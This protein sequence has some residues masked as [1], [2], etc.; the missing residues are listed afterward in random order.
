MTW[1][2]VTTR[3]GCMILKINSLGSK[4]LPQQ[5][6]VSQTLHIP[7]KSLSSGL[8]L[9]WLLGDNLWTLGIFCL[10]SVFIAWGFE[11][12]CYQFDQKS[13]YLW[14]LPIFDLEEG[15]WIWAAEV[16]HMGT[17]CMWMAPSK[18]HRLHGSGEFPWLATLHTCCHTSLPGELS[19]PPHNSTGR[20]H[21]EACAGFS[22]TLP[23]VPF[24]FDDWFVSYPCD[25][26]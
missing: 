21:L 9:G 8:V 24:P 10:K 5:A 17:H 19:M 23:Y 12:C 13:L 25:K 26:L 3:R 16:S 2:S 6:W 18:N 4:E 7:K 14:Y 22:W 1:V 20:G 15:T 11:P